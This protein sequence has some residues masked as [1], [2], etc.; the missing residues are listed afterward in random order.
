[1]ERPLLVELVGM[2][3]ENYRLCHRSVGLCGVAE[4]QDQLA[5]YPPEVREQGRQIQE[6]YERLLFD[7]G[8]RVLP[9]SVGLPSLR[10]LW[11]S[12]RHGLR[13]GEVA[14]VVRGRAVRLAD[15]YEAVRRTVEQALS[16]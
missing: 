6:L 5:D 15:G 16:A 13:A 4:D 3:P 12:L 8:G 1:M 11:L 14:V 10:G 7:F 9:V 2:F